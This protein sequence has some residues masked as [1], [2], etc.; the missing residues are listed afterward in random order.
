MDVVIAIILVLAGGAFGTGLWA[1]HTENV[2]WKDEAKHAFEKYAPLTTR[3]D[4]LRTADVREDPKS[5]PVEVIEEDYNGCSLGSNGRT[6]FRFYFDGENKLTRMQV[7][8]HY[9]GV[10]Q[11][12]LIEER[13]F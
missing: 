1:T 5:N 4:V 10:E 9:A 13:R 11:M 2:C 8:R 7:L 6:A 12:P 3:D